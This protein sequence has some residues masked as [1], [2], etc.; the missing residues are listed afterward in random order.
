MVPITRFSTGSAP[1]L[2]SATMPTIGTINSAMRQSLLRTCTR[3][4]RS[5][6]A[7]EISVSVRTRSGRRAATISEIA[8]PIELPTRCTGPRPDWS[9]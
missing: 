6:T 8:P 3:S 2:R 7:G 9:R 1:S 4:L 5:G